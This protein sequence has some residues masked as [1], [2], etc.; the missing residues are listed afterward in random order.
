MGWEREGH[1]D[2]GGGGGGRGGGPHS[3]R[4]KGL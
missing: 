3:C 4:R 1:R 2:R